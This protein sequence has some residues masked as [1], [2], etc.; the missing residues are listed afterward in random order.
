MKIFLRPC[1]K[2]PISLLLRNRVSVLLKRIRLRAITTVLIYGVS[3]ASPLSLDEDFYNLSCPTMLNNAPVSPRNPSKRYAC[4][5][6]RGQKLRCVREDT[7]YETC[8]RCLRMNAICITNSPHRMGRL[9]RT[10]T[11]RRRQSTLGSD[12]LTPSAVSIGTGDDHIPEVETG[13]EIMSSP[14]WMPNTKL[15]PAGR[16]G[17]SDANNNYC[18]TNST[19]STDLLSLKTSD[20][21]SWQAQV[22]EPMGSIHGNMGIAVPEN[23]ASNESSLVD[24][25]DLSILNRP[26][27]S[28]D[29]SDIF[30]DLTTGGS[31]SDKM[32]L[33][34]LSPLASCPPTPARSTERM[35]ERGWSRNSHDFSNTYP[36]LGDLAVPERSQSDQ[37]GTQPEKRLEK[38][39]IHQLSELNLSLYRQLRNFNSNTVSL[40]LVTLTRSSAKAGISDSNLIGN[41][42]WKYY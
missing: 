42:C 28:L 24:D 7:N 27:P 31:L 26:S 17:P 15:V 22:L 29:T 8:T 5:R 13:I 3:R 39:Y 25:G 14:L 12:R 9:K 34:S 4:D 1:H 11:E 16:Q 33:P 19:S 32:V 21:S 36:A 38:D 6:C 23:T 2:Q 30:A 37:H 41:I 35:M 10:E 20:L 18:S 40:P